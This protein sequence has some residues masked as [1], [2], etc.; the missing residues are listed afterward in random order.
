MVV[1]AGAVVV[2]VTAGAMVVSGGSVEE[3]VVGR[4]AATGIRWVGSPSATKMMARGPSSTT[5]PT[6]TLPQARVVPRAR[7]TCWGGT[8]GLARLA[9]THQV[10]PF[11][12]TDAAL[13]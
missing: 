7:E 3:L 11:T 1:V 2:A 4:W 8:V 6:K 10:K 9:T 13:S 12:W 5:T